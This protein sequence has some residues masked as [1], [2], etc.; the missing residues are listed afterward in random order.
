MNWNIYFDIIFRDYEFDNFTLRAA[1]IDS[2]MVI[3]TTSHF[4]SLS[5]KWEYLSRFG[6]PTFALSPTNPFVTIDLWTTS[7]TSFIPVCIVT[8]R[9]S[10]NMGSLVCHEEWTCVEIQISFILL[11]ETKN[12]FYQDFL[13]YDVNIFTCWYSD[14]RIKYPIFKVFTDVYYILIS[15]LIVI[16]I[17]RTTSSI[18]TKSTIEVSQYLIICPYIMRIFFNLWNQNS[19]IGIFITVTKYSHI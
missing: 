17:T 18:R 14:T 8:I 10:A 12:L 7:H 5:S 6:N 11:N 2:K 3:K 19:L 4:E 1:F 15:P 9:P 16:T 13:L